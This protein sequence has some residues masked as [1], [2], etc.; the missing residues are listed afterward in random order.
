MTTPLIPRPDLLV[1]GYDSGEWERFIGEWMRSQK[2]KYLEVKRVGGANDHG[3]DVVG[4]TDAQKLEGVWD[5]NQC[6]HYRT[7]IPT[8]DGL[9]DVGKL[10]YWAHRGK[11]KP[12]RRSRFVAPKGPCGPL[13]TLLDN[14]S[15]L[16]QA[17]L[18]GWDKYCALEITTSG[19][20]LTPELRSYAEAFDFTIFGWAHID[21]VLED[22]K[23]TAFYAARFGGALPPPPRAVVPVELQK[24]E[25][26]YIGQLLDVY[27]EDLGRQITNYSD[28]PEGHETSADFKRQR[29]RFF[30]MEFFAHHYRDQT[31]PNTIEDF[32][33]EVY[34]AVQPVCAREYPQSFERLNETMARAAIIETKSILEKQAKGRV[35]QG[36]CHH[37]ANEDRLKW[38]R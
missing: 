25:S 16:K 3:L 9:A 28:L 35:K 23:T 13:R 7:S 17:I 19:A 5:N 34:D 11:F 1:M 4:Y 32:V 24:R 21:E 38:K 26:R 37:L 22:L 15:Q 33:E 8:A 20:P 10:I 18:E 31:P 27:S 6:K 30:E 12:P 2:D 14:P 36:A 29:E